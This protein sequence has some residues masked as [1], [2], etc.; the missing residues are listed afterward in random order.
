MDVNNFLTKFIV[1]HR[2]ARSVSILSSN[3]S[4]REA[5]EKKNATCVYVHI[6]VSMAEKHEP[7]PAPR[8]GILS[9]LDYAREM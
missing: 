5:K 1:R 9:P 6:Y 4:I 2:A 3:D 7:S 8:Y